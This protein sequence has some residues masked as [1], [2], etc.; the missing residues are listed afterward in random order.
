[1][2]VAVIGGGAAG[3]FAAISVKE[4]HP[5]SN[6]VLFEKSPKVLSKVKVS[7]GGRCNVTH[8]CFE[9]SELIKHYPRGAKFLKKS[10]HQFKVIDTID[11][12]DTF[13]VQ[14]KTE[15]DNRMF[16]TTDN[17]QTIIDCL[18]NQFEQ[19]GCV[20]K[21][22]SAVTKIAPLNSNKGFEL[23]VNDKKMSFDKIIL[24][25]GG[26]PKIEGLKWL[27][28]LGHKIEK[29]VPSL[30][31]FNMPKHPITTLMGAVAPN[32]KV[33]IE[34]E[35]LE[36]TG[37]L[38]I[39]HWGMSGPAVLKLSSFGA[40]K[41]AEK[42]YQFNILVS[43]LGQLSE[44]AVRALFQKEI[45]NHSLSQISNY[46]LPEIPKRLWVYLVEKVGIELDK[47]WC[48]FS[49]KDLN[50]LVNGLVNDSYQVQGKTTFKEEFVT[51]GGVSLADVNPN[52]M[53]S[54]KIPGIYFSGE[55]LD[56]DGVTG[57]FNFQAAWTTGF[58]AGKL[59]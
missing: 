5:K 20:L 32:V 39:T 24:A 41:L 16:P 35:K 34:G 10:F 23:I 28:N 15:S 59:S 22:Q 57:G 13:N 58:I 42:N 45:S 14:L 38:L 26:S 4:H 56:I 27:Q 54:K 48:D 29:P 12:F 30:F 49:K 2:K 3:F 8:S 46:K 1:M 9:I 25:T 21:L 55:L 43:W 19:L 7:G 47:R 52:S 18:T 31:T 33:R 53:E 37:P 44:D 40:R 36:S 6:V 50:R 11:W 51:C 17:S